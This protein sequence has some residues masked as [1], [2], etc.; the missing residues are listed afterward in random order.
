MPFET[1]PEEDGLRTGRIGKRCGNDAG[2]RRCAVP[3]RNKG[4]RPIIS[5]A[6]NAEEPPI[7]SSR[8][9]A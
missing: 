9:S 8:F 5:R 7:E 1:D 4:A 2:A 6:A 3:V